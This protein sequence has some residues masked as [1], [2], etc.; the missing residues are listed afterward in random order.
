MTHRRPRAWLLSATLAL[1]LLGALAAGTAGAAPAET[2]PDPGSVPKGLLH[3]LERDLGLDAD[4]ARTRAAAEARATTTAARLRAAL[5]ATDYAGLWYDAA[6]GKLKAAVTDAAT[7]RRATQLGATAQRVTHDRATLHGAARA[8]G[9]SAEKSKG[10]GIP[11]IVA[12]GVDERR[13]QVT[14]TVAKPDRTATTDR[15]L[16]RAT[17]LGSY[18]KVREISSAPTQQGGEVAGGEKWVPGSESPCSIGFSATGSADAKSFLTAGHCTNDANQPAY[19]KDGTRIGTSNVNGS[20]SINAR[21]GDFGAVAVDQAGWTL[22]PRVEGWSSTDV[23]VTGSAEGVVGQAVCRS[24]QTSGWRCG[25]ITQVNQTVDYG[26]VVIDGLS[27]SDACSAGGD[28]GGSYVTASGAKAVG[29]HSGGGSA[30]CGSSGDTFTIFQPVNEALQKWGLTLTT[31]TQQPGEV[32]VA[33]VADRQSAVGE[34][35]ELKNSATGGTLPYTWSASG[36]PAGLAIDAGTGTVTGTPTAEGTHAVKVTATDKD[37]KSGSTAF[38][39]TVGGT[40]GGD[41]LLTDP[42]SQTVYIGKPVS[43]QLAAT[44]G[45]APL[46]WSATGLPAGLSIDPATGKVTGTPTTW[47]TAGSR[48]T[49]TD[50]EGKA[51]TLDITWYVFF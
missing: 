36:L 50:R 5:P 51:D 11:G 29:I 38:T 13:N 40:S 10:K 41:P 25:E 3:A 20:H 46:R 8:I 16:R 27:Y 31:G 15:F 42:G 28:S 2:D 37:G 45:T 24:G 39:W 32:Q 43:L 34:A 35:A 48:V 23:D 9:R 21:E 18:V 44:G 6:T 4:A 1:S 22:S 19:G 7:A 26:N 17:S 47:G 14:I 33:A 49:V 30:T 12:W